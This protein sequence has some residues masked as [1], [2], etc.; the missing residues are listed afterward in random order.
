MLKIYGV[1]DDLIEFEGDIREESYASEDGNV[2]TL[3]NGVALR[4]RYNEQGVWRI[5]PISGA[6]DVEQAPENDDL[7]YSDVATVHDTITWVA[8]GVDIHT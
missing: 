7:N 8:V 6:V 3:S 4:I 1:S 2:V 5:T